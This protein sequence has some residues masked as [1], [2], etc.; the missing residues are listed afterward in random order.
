M[1]VLPFQYKVPSSLVAI[2]FI[3]FITHHIQ[4]AGNLNALHS[5]SMTPHRQISVNILW[6]LHSPK[7][8]VVARSDKVGLIQN[9]QEIITRDVMV[10]LS[11]EQVNLCA[12]IVDK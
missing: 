7:G 2:L 6:N 1:N 12:I 8:I 9:T 11:M 4:R 3:L 5:L 10:V